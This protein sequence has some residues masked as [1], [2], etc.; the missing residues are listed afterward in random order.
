M[1]DIAV[2]LA[3]VSSATCCLSVPMAIS[4]RLL[5]ASA[6]FMD[7]SRLAFVAVSTSSF[8]CND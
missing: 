7:L 4:A 2:D 6:D 3:V 1:C 8:S 5:S